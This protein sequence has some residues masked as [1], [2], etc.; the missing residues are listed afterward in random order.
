V[1]REMS[2]TIVATKLELFG[3][4]TEWFENLKMMIMINN[5]SCNNNGDANS[6]FKLKNLTKEE[7][8]EEQK[9]TKRRRRH[10]ICDTLARRKIN[11]ITK[12]SS[13]HRLP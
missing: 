1:E 7:T 6:N 12:L 8:E 5:T 13:K 2:L 9:K 4:K 11:V 10:G 3:M